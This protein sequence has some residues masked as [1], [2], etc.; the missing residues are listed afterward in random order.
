MKPE[1]IYQAETQSESADVA[2]VVLPEIFG[3]TDFI[4]HFTN[5]LGQDTYMSAYALDF[6]FALTGKSNKFDYQ[7]DAARGIELMQ[8]MTGERFLSIYNDAIAHIIQKQ[9]GLKALYIVGFCFGGRLSYVAGLNDM[10]T[11]L[12][13]FYGAG[14]NMPDYVNGR[15]AI[16]ALSDKRAGDS[17]LS[18]LSFYGGL[19]ESI[20]MPDRQKTQELLAQASIIYESVVYDDA[21]HAFMN[22]ERKDRYHAPSADKAYQKLLTFLQD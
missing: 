9:P 15:S 12:V 20:P 19:D 1:Y 6:F 5:K 14:A 4:E 18:V 17:S 13:S 7:Q 16:E 21:G 10:A 2:I 8:Q 22:N 3:I 11:K